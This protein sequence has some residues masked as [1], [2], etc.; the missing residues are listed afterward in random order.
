MGVSLAKNTCIVRFDENN[1]ICP[2]NGISLFLR[3]SLQT[4]IL[5]KSK[6]HYKQV[7]MHRINQ[8]RMNYEFEFQEYYPT[9]DVE[10]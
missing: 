8:Q 10:M 4:M 2:S 9:G 7:Y 5:N 6:H 3:Q 1:S